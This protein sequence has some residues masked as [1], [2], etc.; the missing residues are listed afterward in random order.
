MVVRLATAIVSESTR[1][2]S[3]GS[4]VPARGRRRRR[5]R[6]ARAHRG[7]QNAQT[8]FAQRPPA[9]SGPLL[10]TADQTF[11]PWWVNHPQILRRRHTYPTS[12]DRQRCWQRSIPG[13]LRVPMIGPKPRRL[14]R[15]DPPAPYPYLRFPA[16]PATPCAQPHPDRPLPSCCQ[17]LDR[18]AHQRS[19]NPRPPSRRLPVP[20][21]SQAAHTAHSRY[22]C[23]LLYPKAN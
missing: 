20:P 4:P 6:T 22:P 17:G 8:R 19:D 16:P 10:R 3:L 7:L 14:R 5:G 2:A 21:I 18:A 11:L 12:V 15:G 13:V 1:D 9:S 23:F